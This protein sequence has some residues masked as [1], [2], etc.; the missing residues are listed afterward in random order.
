VRFAAQKPICVVKISEFIQNLVD[1]AAAYSWIE[2]CCFTAREL[3]SSS[4]N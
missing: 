2:F 1:S 4:A 3:L